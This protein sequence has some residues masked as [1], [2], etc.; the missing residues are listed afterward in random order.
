MRLLC[1][2][3]PRRTVVWPTSCSSSSGSYAH[4]YETNHERLYCN[5]F[6]VCF[7]NESLPSVKE[8]RR[9]YMDVVSGVIV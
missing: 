7:L 5:G 8:T 9:V 2:W 6:I 1:R 3:F 4:L